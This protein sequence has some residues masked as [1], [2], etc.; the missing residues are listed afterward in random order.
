[1]R[2]SAPALAGEGQDEAAGGLLAAGEEE[3]EVLA[4][5]LAESFFAAAL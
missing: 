3:V 2:T 5:A 4:L 1:M